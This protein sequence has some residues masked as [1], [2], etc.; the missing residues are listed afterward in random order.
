VRAHVAWALGEIGA[1]SG[2]A[3][4][5]DSLAAR[6]L[7]EEDPEVQAELDLALETCRKAPSLVR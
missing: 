4:A 3:R 5:V 6:R 7:V 1:R 2:D